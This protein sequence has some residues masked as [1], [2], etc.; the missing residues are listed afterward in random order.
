RLTVE[1]VAIAGSTFIYQDNV[2]L[3]GVAPPDDQIRQLRRCLAWAASHVE[4]RPLVRVR[5]TRRD[6][7]NL[8]RQFS[9]RSSPA[10]LEH[11]V[12]SAPQLLLYLLDVARRQCHARRSGAGCRRIGTG[13]GSP[14][15]RDASQSECR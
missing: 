9:S 4:D 6:E 11:I 3:V 15:C 14:Q 7:N 5:L 12:N 13:E 1:A 8:Q 10:I 2:V